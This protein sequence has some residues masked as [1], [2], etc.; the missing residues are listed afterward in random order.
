MEIAKNTTELNKKTLVAFQNVEILKKSWLI[1]ICSFV[2]MVLS[3]GVQDGHVYLNC[4]PILVVG[5]LCW[6]FYVV[7]LKILFIKQ[8]KKFETM[9]ISYTFSDEKIMVSGK[10]ASGE[11]NVEIPYEN[12][13][14]ARQTKKFI[15]LYVTKDSA[16]VVDK[17]K[18]SY[19]D[20]DKVMNLIKLKEED[21]QDEKKK[22]SA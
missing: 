11:E 7:L 2:I 22:K 18:F 3:F 9:M 1:A 5:A 16:L 14:K 4:I 21:K 20:A 19:G 6:P 12:L 15:F 13:F 17:S 10:S 8:N